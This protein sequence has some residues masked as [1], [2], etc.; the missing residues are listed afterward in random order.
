MV[1]EYKLRRDALYQILKN[2]NGLDVYMPHAGFYFFPDFVNLIP[3]GLS[4][5]ERK[6]YAYKK[7]MDAGIATV[8]GACFEHYFDTNVRFSYSATNL[9]VIKEAGERLKVIF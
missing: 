1:N 5:E 7:M 2:I 8:Y 4:D 6:L 3:S 9:N